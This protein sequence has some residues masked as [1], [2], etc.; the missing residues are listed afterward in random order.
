MNFCPKGFLTGFGALSADLLTVAFFAAF[1]AG[2]G[3][4]AGAS[5]A[6][7]F[8]EGAFLA[9]AFLAGFFLAAIGT[10]RSA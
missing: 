9:T 7:V 5:L 1:L 6:S 3:F 2:L 8:F 10:L 4:R